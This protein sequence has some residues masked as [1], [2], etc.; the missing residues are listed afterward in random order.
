M[1]IF[2]IISLFGG[3]ALFLYGM[4]TMGDGL[5]ASSSGALKQ[6]LGKVTNNHF[7]GFLLGLIVTAVIQ[8]S[9]ATIV[10]LSGLVGAGLITLRQSL[11]II[12]GANVGTTVTGQIIRLL[13]INAGANLWL[14]FFKPSTLAPIAAIAGIIVIMTRKDKN[15]NTLGSILMGFGVLFTG[16]LNMTAAVAPL[17]ESAAFA[18]VFVR[19]S[20]TPLLGFLAGTGVAF[21]IQSSSATIGILQALSMTGV[22]TFSAVWPIIIGVNMGDCITTAIVCSIGSSADAKRTGIIHILFNIVG[23]IIVI[24][25]VTVLHKLGVLDSLWNKIVNSGAIANTHTAFRLTTAI[26]LLPVCTSFEKLSRRIVKDDVS[27]GTSV[28]KELEILEEKLYGS[29]ALA[30][31]SAST[32]ISSMAELSKQGVI[33]ALRLFHKYDAQKIDEIRENEDRIDNLADHV[34]NYLIH[35]SPSVS[36]HDSDLL[37]LYIQCFG[38]FERVGDYAVN[39]TE[40]LQELM[41]KNEHFSDLALQELEIISAAIVEIL[42]YTYTGFTEM[43]MDAARKI[44]PVEEVIDDLVATLRTNHIKRLRDGTCS[45]YAGLVFLDILVNVERVADQCSNVGVFLLS[46]ADATIMDNHHDYIR[47]L[48]QGDDPVFNNAYKETYA[49]YFG[50][51]DT[52]ENNPGPKERHHDRDY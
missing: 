49:K 37:N 32:A 31:S 26:T 40:N 34:D 36:G 13:D 39:L 21:T 16:L 23:S 30:L 52:V 29:P 43:D 8:S 41:D 51:L 35:M 4:R 7:Y 46:Q 24:I 22:L 17:S 20:R 12:L 11:G 15:S 44:E 3:L 2:N 33:D 6:A 48:H 5:K 28:D 18:N 19:L 27:V 1:T 9:T 25:G 38:E 50:S 14:N 45:V 10:L 42:E 47:R